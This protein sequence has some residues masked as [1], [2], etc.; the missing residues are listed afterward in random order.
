MVRHSFAGSAT[1]LA[2]HHPMPLAWFRMM[3]VPASS[4]LAELRCAC[5]LSCVPVQQ[6]QMFLQEVAELLRW[7]PNQTATMTYIGG[8][9]SLQAR[10]LLRVQDVSLKSLLS[11]Y[12]QDFWVHGSGGGLGAAF[13]HNFHRIKITDGVQYSRYISF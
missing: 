3:Q 12:P 13:V 2:T 7:E 9:L 11:C 8:R 4:G 5:A 6:V 1:G 10:R